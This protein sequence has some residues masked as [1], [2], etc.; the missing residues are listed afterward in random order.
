MGEKK[1]YIGKRQ[2]ISVA[3]TVHSTN[4]TRTEFAFLHFLFLSFVYKT[5]R[6]GILDWP[7]RTV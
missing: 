6:Y 3:S 2:E 5:K 1:I 7:E 4:K